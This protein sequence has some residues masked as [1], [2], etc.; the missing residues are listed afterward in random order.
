[1]LD[2]YL[3]DVVETD[4]LRFWRSSKARPVEIGVAVFEGE[5][6]VTDRELFVQALTH[7]IGRAKAYGCGL[8]TVAG[9]QQ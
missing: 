5:L 6:E 9:L 7:G 4:H 1:M 3:F 8:L 2:E